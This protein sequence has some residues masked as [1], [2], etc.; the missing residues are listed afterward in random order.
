MN[1]TQRRQTINDRKDSTDRQIRLWCKDQWKDFPI[2][3]V[4]VDALLL[5]VDNRRFASERTLMQ[6]KLGHALDPENS[7]NDELSVISI[8]LDV[9]LDV[10]GDVVKGNPS[11]D[12]EGLKADW[13]RRKQATPFWIRPDGSVRNGNRR[14][15][16]IKRM[17]TDGITGTGWVETVILDPDEVDERDLFEME[18]REQLTEDYK[19]RYTDLNLLLTLRQ[20]AV[21]RGIDWFDQESIQ[22]VAGELQEVS[23]G[24]KGY[25][26]IQLQAI[27]SMDAYLLDAGSPGEY[28]KLFRQVERF[29][30]IGKIMTKLEED[31][32]TDA[33]DMMQLLF[34]AIRAGNPHG[35]IRVIRNMFI[36]DKERY[37][38]LQQQVAE[39]EN[40]WEA[41]GE[42]PIPEPNLTDFVEDDQN[43][44]DED[45]PVDTTAPVAPNY[46]TDL[47]KSRIKNSIDG[48]GASNLDVLS[49]LEQIA[50]RVD[51]LQ[52][53]SELL[54]QELGGNRGTEARQIL[55]RILAWAEEAKKY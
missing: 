8:L 42:H 36:R 38:R 31:Y 20:A 33:P 15:A 48:F 34:A 43:D 54:S 24:D 37:Q 46:P 45:E 32:P 3:R 27:K 28:H 29:R 10:D 53:A 19:V 4:P 14:L 6:S 16:M 47:V 50:S 9:G 11:K 26:V 12:Y 7:D 23:G 30:D 35:D 55:G 40:E 18:Q 13:Q 41:S 51:I 21:D 49:T 17:R 1:A 44:S 25:A 2:F 5:N 22:S 39:D 52:K